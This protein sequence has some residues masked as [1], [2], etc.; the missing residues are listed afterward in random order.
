MK[1][2]LL[3]L[4]LIGFAT[5]TQSYSQGVFVRIGGGYGLPASGDD[6]GLREITD[7]TGLQ[8]QALVYGSN[9]QGTVFG[10]DVGY[11]INDHIGFQLGGEFLLGANQVRYEGTTPVLNE[12]T[13]ERSNQI[14]VLPAVLVSG[15]LGNIDPYCRVGVSLPLMTTTYESYIGNSEVP[16]T[17]ASAKIESEI[18]G[19]FVLGY[20]GALGCNFS[21]GS[22]LFLFA[23]LGAIS[24]RLKASEGTLT[25][26]EF[27]GIDGLGDLDV[28]DK[29]WNYLESVTTDDNSILLNPDVDRSQPEDRQQISQN[30]SS[31]YLKA[32]V[33]IYFGGADID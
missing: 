16:N 1:H 17:I 28:I 13:Q 29:E 32:G 18:T 31:F 5:F 6:Y 10:L 12:L 4:L 27:D 19:K 30:L 2:R 22:R 24:Q 25:I 33:S 14:R 8:S 21:L 26:Y 7:S 3:F 15:G 20:T 23:E 11:M 9:G